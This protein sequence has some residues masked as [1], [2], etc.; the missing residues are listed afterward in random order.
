[1][2]RRRIAA[3]LVFGAIVPLRAGAEESDA[4][5]TLPAVN[6]VGATPLPGLELPRDRVPA[7]VQ[8]ATGAEI[9]NSGALSLA[10]FMNRRLGSVHVNE[11]QGNPFQPDVSFR[12]YT[13]SPLLGTPQG[14]SVYVDGIRVNQPFGDI[15][16]WDLLPR[17]AI[18]SIALM[19]GSNPLFGLNTLGG[20]LAV[21]TKDGF[22]EPGSSFQLTAGSYGRV[23]AEGE[24]GGNDGHGFAW[25]GAAN[26]FRESGWRDD[27]AS[28]LGQV[29]GK[30]SAGAR[31]R[32]V[33]RSPRPRHRPTCTAMAC[34]KRSCSKR[35]TRASTRCLTRRAIAPASSASRRA[36]TSTSAGPCRGTHICAA[37]TRTP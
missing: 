26:V 14:L 4:T 29:F 5:S 6:V 3:L 28:E 19:P 32:R 34:R 27:S 21:Q 35:A 23:M 8:T 11:I 2:T 1:M 18:A 25:Y 31:V 24:S 17:T 20:A 15:V 12:G 36:T 37:S 9:A 30:R 10:D 22:T 13:A 16:S 33:S 7:P